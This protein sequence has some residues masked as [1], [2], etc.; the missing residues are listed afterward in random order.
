MIWVSFVFTLL[1][2]IA[3]AVFAFVQG[4]L[5]KSPT[6]LPLTLPRPGS[7]PAGVIMLIMAVV[8]LIMMIVWRNRVAFSALLLS[9]GVEVV[10]KY[11]ATT[12]LAFVAILVQVC[13]YCSPAPYS[14][15]L[16]LS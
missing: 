1:L 8:F 11:P 15:F 3:V 6:T 13:C 5:T 16:L 10:N 14:V 2:F 9:T 12:L 7:I 4:S